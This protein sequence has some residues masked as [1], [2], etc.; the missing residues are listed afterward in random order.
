MN[1]ELREDEDLGNL[2]YLLIPSAYQN[3]YLMQV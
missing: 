3:L 2:V 1:C